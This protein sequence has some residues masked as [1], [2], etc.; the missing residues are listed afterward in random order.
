MTVAA[1]GAPPPSAFVRRA[2]RRGFTVVEL[3]VAAAVFSL[4]LLAIMGVFRQSMD[5]M[6]RG[7]E[8]MFLQTEVARIL[9]DI[10]FELT[11]INP[12]PFLDK[13]G[14][15]WIAG[16]RL[17]EVE[18]NTVAFTDWDE[19]TER[20]YDTITWRDHA[21]ESLTDSEVVSYHLDPDPVVARAFRKNETGV[22][23]HLMKRR[24]ERV[25]PVSEHVV[26]CDFVPVDGAVKG[27]R[28]DGE[29]A[30]KTLNGPVKRLPFQFFVRLE[31]PYL[32]LVKP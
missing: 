26:R 9:T 6:K 15:L 5:Q 30:L 1:P 18:P 24:G 32:A 2:R 12:R 23:H 13:A 4:I 20:G 29:V 28:I 19:R 21:R 17:G 10:Y 7:D 27:V 22:A 14:D 16:E 8:E 3:L 25:A 11:S 31:S